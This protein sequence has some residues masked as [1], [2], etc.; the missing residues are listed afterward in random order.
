MC[1]T[2][3]CWHRGRKIFEPPRFMHTL[4]AIEQLLSLL[5]DSQEED[6]FDP[7]GT[8]AISIAKAGSH[9]SQVLLAGTLARLAQCPDEQFG[10]ELHSFVIVGKRY[11]P[12]E[13]DFAARFAVDRQEW[14]DVSNS[15]YKCRD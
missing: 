12:M 5:Q 2:E 9:T 13:R 14:L 8:L 11:H 10:E 1:F 15:V 4:Q 3:S 7:S 6:K